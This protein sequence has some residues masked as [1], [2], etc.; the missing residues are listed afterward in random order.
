MRLIRFRAIQAFGTKKGR[1]LFGGLTMS[2]DEQIIN[3]GYSAQI[4]QENAGPIYVDRDTIGQFT[5]LLDRAGVEI[6]EGDIVKLYDSMG[7]YHGTTKV[8]WADEIAGFNMD[9]M[10][11]VW[12][13][14]YQPDYSEQVE[15]IGNIHQHKELLS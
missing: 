11:N 15:V 12:D 9:F 4:F 8:Y 6:Y 7:Y 14:E 5:G 1:W 2:N 10:E 13:A 3:E